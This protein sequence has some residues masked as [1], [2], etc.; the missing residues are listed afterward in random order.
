M[1]QVFKRL[2]MVLLMLSTTSLSMAEWDDESPCSGQTC[3]ET[4]TDEE[5]LFQMSAVVVKQGQ[6]EPDINPGSF[7]EFEAL[8]NANQD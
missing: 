1:A 6:E 4:D 5:V 7:D 3:D 2:M 8:A